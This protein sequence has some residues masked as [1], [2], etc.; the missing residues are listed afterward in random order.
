MKVDYH[1][2]PAGSSKTGFIIRYFFNIVRT[3]INFHVRWPWV[4]YKG[5]VRVM[6]GT[7]FAHFEINLGKNVQFGDYCNIATPVII[8]N[9]VLM[10]GRVCFVGKNDH[11]TNLPG[12][13]IWNSPRGDN[14]KTIVEDDVWIGHGVTVIGP[15][16]ISK[17]SVIAAGAVVT[18]DIPPCEIWGGVPARK[19]KDRFATLQ[20]KLI[21]LKYLE[22]IN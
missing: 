21:H 16:K 17:G 20:E 13:T 15:V 10:A 2:F 9:D 12:C 8:G 14:G 4:K 18:K 11:T 7:S 1:N 5:F 22:S 6:K 3:W 19:I